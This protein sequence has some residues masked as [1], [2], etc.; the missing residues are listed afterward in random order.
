[1]E[2]DTIKTTVR[3]NMV[4]VTI[5]QSKGGIGFFGGPV[6][7]EIID[8]IQFTAEFIEDVPA[9][10]IGRQIKNLVSVIKTKFNKP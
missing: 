1:M 8:S 9:E 5:H 2:K 7:Y 4:T 3:R 10:A 6:N